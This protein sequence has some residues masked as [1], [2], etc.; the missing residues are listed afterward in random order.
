MIGPQDTIS[1]MVLVGDTVSPC[2]AFAVPA[3]RCDVEGWLLIWNSG[4]S[5]GKSFYIGIQDTS[6]G[7]ENGVRCD[8]LILVNA[9]ETWAKYW[10]E[11][12]PIR[13]GDKFTLY[14]I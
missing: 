13:P 14:H 11:K 4:V 9:T 10:G 7:V 3:M 2:R 8:S 12:V 6:G 1:G 5:T